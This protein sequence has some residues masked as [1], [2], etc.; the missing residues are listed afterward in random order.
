[1]LLSLR[2]Q[3]LRVLSLLI[4]IGLIVPPP[5]VWAVTPTIEPPVTLPLSGSLRYPI[6]LD[7]DRVPTTNPIGLP[8][9]VE[10][11]G[12]VDQ[13]ESVLYATVQLGVEVVPADAAQNPAG[14][15]V[16]LRLWNN[17]D[18]SGKV[19][20]TR[21]ARADAWG[22]AFTDFLI[23]DLH[24]LA[25]TPYY[26]QASAPGFGS[27]EV[28]SF[29]FDL[30]RFSSDTQVGAAQ[31]QARVETDGRLIVD[32]T[33]DLPIDEALNAAEIMAVRI[34][35][36][37]D[38]ADLSA[39]CCRRCWPSVSTIITPAPKSIWRRDITRCWR[40]S[41]RARAQPTVCL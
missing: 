26:Y 25:N 41:A 20:L 8:V 24:L 7:G 39:M 3:L 18:G 40:K 2:V 1:M 22:A 11:F 10:R 12:A 38:P 19:D 34:T 13:S 17:A 27:T 36:T 14:T 30:N 9:P 16:T 31:L 5:A 33:S 32:I 21:E 28:R 37:A 23:D 35:P 29:T 4:V 15:L 6:E